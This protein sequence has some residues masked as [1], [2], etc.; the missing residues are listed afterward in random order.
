MSSAEQADQADFPDQEPESQSDAGHTRGEARSRSGQ[1]RMAEVAE[2]DEAPLAYVGLRDL[3]VFVV[4]LSIFGG[5]DSWVRATDLNLAAFVLVVVGLLGGAA[6]AGIA[7]EW[8]HF[9]GARLAGGHSPTK[10]LKAFPQVFAFDYVGNSAKSFLWMSIGG[11]IGNW[12]M[13]ALFAFALPL[14]TLGADALVGGAVGFC[15]FSALIEFPIIRKVRSGMSGLEA[16]G[17]IPRDVT[18]RYV[19]KAVGAALLTFIIL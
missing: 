4:L 11:N 14:G 16:L 18:T 7:H 13:A 15:V 9:V 6:A 5:A 19:P 12:G 10:P 1:R 2:K 3:T 17:Q 8:G